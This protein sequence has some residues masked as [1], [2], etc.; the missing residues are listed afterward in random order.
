M[1]LTALT[2]VD[3]LTDKELLDSND[4]FHSERRRKRT[5]NNLMENQQKQNGNKVRQSCPNIKKEYFTQF[6]KLITQ[7]FKF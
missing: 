5:R 3:L 7:N 6:L 1:Q 4:Q 2:I